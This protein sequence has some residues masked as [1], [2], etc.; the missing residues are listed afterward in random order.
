MRR[1][2]IVCTLGPSCREPEVLRALIRAGMDVARLNLSHGAQAE[3]RAVF[4]VVRALAAQEGR[5]V[6][7]LLDLQ[8]PKMRT[9]KLAGGGPVHLEEG[10]AFCISAREVPG[11]SRCVSTTYAHLPLDV[12]VKDRILL[13]EGAME[14]EVARVTPPEVYCR[15]IRGGE[16]GQHKGINLPG[17]AVSAAA[18][19]EKD[20]ED[21][22]FGIALGVDYVALSFVRRADDVHGIKR[23]IAETG[24]DIRVV[25]KIER[26]EALA[27]FDAILDATDVVMVARGDLG[28]EVD[29][30]D[31]PQ[32]QKSL[33]AK[34]HA[35]GKPVITAT[36]ML[37][38][39]MDSPRP[40][41]AEVTDVANAIY[42]GTDA[43]MLSGETAAGKF[44]IEAVAVMADIAQK[45]DAAVS[46]LPR[47]PMAPV[48][49]AG[50][51]AFGDAIGRAVSDMVRTLPVARIV[52][53][54]MSGFT[55]GAISRY[56]PPA[57]ITA[58]TL[59]ED[60]RRRC[61]LYWGVDA[62]AA[63]EMT[64]TETMM[65]VVDGMLL[66]RGLAAP[67]NVIIVVAGTPL[68]IGGRTNLLRLH[69][70]GEAS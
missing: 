42:D 8:G 31:V 41:R 57:P 60:A 12:K 36:Q 35:A 62:V 39:M 24:R 1:T 54:T 10:A 68:A 9:G 16:L 46:A 32:I 7:V 66:A 2:K 15:V 28:I 6:A 44:P 4:D 14:L 20:I 26:P 47:H 64:D 25:A 50:E 29:L 67:G 38:S 27:D 18:L 59:S 13:A 3:H 52:C 61:A 56:R 40:T 58:I 22:Q 48:A 49:D 19:T 5:N 21:L 45:A 63:G 34:S 51:G 37:E 23:R 17:V 70:V 11:D 33:I 53:L 43:V 55:A 69:R 30:A 65:R